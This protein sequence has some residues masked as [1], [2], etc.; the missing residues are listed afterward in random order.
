M[1]VGVREKDIR[2]DRNVFF[3][4]TLMSQHHNVVL[5][6]TH[7]LTNTLTLTHTHNWLTVASRSNGSRGFFRVFAIYFWTKVVS[8][9]FFGR[10]GVT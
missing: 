10:Q 2:T 9:T 8:K 7:T 1:F 5:H 3:S 6:Y 4:E